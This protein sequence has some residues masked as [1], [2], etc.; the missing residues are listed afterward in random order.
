MPLSLKLGK[1][2]D[3]YPR[4]ISAIMDFHVNNATQKVREVTTDCNMCFAFFK[5]NYLL[6]LTDKQKMCMFVVYMVFI[7]VCVLDWLK[8]TN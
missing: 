2:P 6:I 7:N 5:K 4:P 1:H 3:L 8:Q